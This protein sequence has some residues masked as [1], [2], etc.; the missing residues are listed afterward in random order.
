MSLRTE[1]K[2]QLGDAL[3]LGEF[4]WTEWF[5]TK[6]TRPFMEGVEYARMLWE[7]GA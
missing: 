4:D 7:M 6:P 1:L 3:V 2:W 5:E